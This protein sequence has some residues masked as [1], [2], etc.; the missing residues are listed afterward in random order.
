LI[1]P[2]SDCHPEHSEGSAFQHCAPKP[3]VDRFAVTL[4][5]ADVSREPQVTLE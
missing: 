3:A 1:T 5:A 2:F 4:A